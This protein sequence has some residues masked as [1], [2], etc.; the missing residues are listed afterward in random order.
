L[1][2]F[3]NNLDWSVLTDALISV[4]PALICIILHEMSHAY[5]AYRLG[6]NTAK[7]L[8]RLTLNPIKHL[9]IFGLL[10]MMFIGFGWAKPVPIDYRN[11]KHPKRGMALTALAGP[12]TNLLIAVVTL[13]IYGLLIIPLSAGAVGATVLKMIHRLALFSTSLAVFNIL[14]IPPM[15]GSKVFFAIASDE[16]YFKLM[17][18][19]RFGFILILILA[20]SGKLWGP[21]STAISF[22]FDKLLIVAQAGLDL[23]MLFL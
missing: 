1:L 21:L 7:S 11:F 2:T 12:V 6:D 22:V 19:E 3:L 17:R 20:F 15:D 16:L 9:D 23:A 10:A 5:V 14:P 18:Y 8:G 13:F 4:I